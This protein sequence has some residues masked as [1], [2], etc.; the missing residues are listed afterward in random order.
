[1]SYMGYMGWKEFAQAA[2]TLMDSSTD[3]PRRTRADTDG[4][5][6]TRTDN[7][8][9]QVAGE[10]FAGILGAALFGLIRRTY[11]I[12]KI[13]FL[14]AGDFVARRRFNR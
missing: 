11:D 12:V 10:A 9:K 4:H 2:E 14:R 8:G 1:M 5:G 6:R 3:G 13:S 7:K